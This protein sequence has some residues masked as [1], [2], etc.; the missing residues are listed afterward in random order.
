LGSGG[1]TKGS[2]EDG[3]G[4]TNDSMGGSRDG[5]MVGT[6]RI[7]GVKNDKEQGSAVE[8]VEEKEPS[9][10]QTD[11]ENNDIEVEMEA[12]SADN[13]LKDKKG[14][15]VRFTPDDYD[16]YQ[17]KS[18][19]NVLE[20]NDLVEFT[21]VT[22][23]RSGIKYARNI[24]LI[25]SQRERIEEEREQKLLQS[26]TLECGIVVSLKKG[27]GFLKSNQRREEIYFH[28]SHVNFPE[29]DG[30]GNAFTLEEGQDMEF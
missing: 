29:Q 12:S 6:I 24:T 26:A 18:R 27:Y 28:F 10:E 2:E 5:A 21:L 7:C 9:R 3:E 16:G 22:E 19:T 17:S 11:A 4:G 8:L 23:K 14:T 20:R 25:Q 1:G 15:L 13:K 30:D